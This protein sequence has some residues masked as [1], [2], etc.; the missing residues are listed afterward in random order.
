MNLLPQLKNKIWSFKT[1]FASWLMKSGVKPVIVYA[2]D[3]KLTLSLFFA[4]TTRK[5]SVGGCFTTA[6]ETLAYLSNNKAGILITTLK[7]EDSHGDRLIELAKAIQPELRCVLVADHNNY[8]AADLETWRSSVIIAEDDI[9]DVSE[10]WRMALL[11]AIADTSYRSK[12]IERRQT[13]SQPTSRIALTPREQDILQCFA[14]G[15][16]NAEAAQRRQLS[17]HST[18]TYST[19]LLTKLKV[20]N[21]Q[22][23]LLK[24]F[25]NALP[26][27]ARM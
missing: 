27:E 19:R 9:G 21:R 22:L 20:S 26:E 8:S 2:S 11:S 14:M 18:K 5:N 3:S 15:L 10:P 13:P 17:P 4:S 24:V 7:L 23:A 6:E 1:T 16:S 25:G 12:S